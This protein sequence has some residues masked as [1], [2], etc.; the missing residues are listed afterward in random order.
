MRKPDLPTF[1]IEQPLLEALTMHKRLVLT[2]P[3]GS[4]KST[5]VPQ[6]L[7]DGGLLR[8]GQ[9]TVLQPRRL[10]TR[11]LAAWVAQARDVRLG[12]EVGYQIRLDNVTSPATRICYVTEG[13]LLRRML[14]DPGL[15][16]VSAIVFDEFHER[17]LYGDITLARA[18][19]IQESTRPDLIIIVMS[20]TL[21][22]AA[23]QKYLHPC[24][25]LSSQGRTYPVAIEYL[26]QPAGEAP[27][28][29]LAVREL[30][31]LVRRHSQGDA[32]IF[33]PGAYEIT[34]TVQAA[35][36][37][38]GRQ[39]VVFPLHGELPP[40]DQ[41]AAVA[42]YDRRKIVVA[43]N[44][45]ETSLT[46]DGVRLVI[47][48]GLARIPRYDPYRGINTLLVEKISRAAAD[49]RAGRAGRTAPGH[50]LRLWTAHD[51]AARAAQELSEVKRLDLSEVIL[52]LKASGVKDVR[53]F[54][55]LEP[56]DTRA[57][58]R[59][60]KLLTD[61][62]AIDDT[63]GAITALGR[64]M[65]AFPAH[66]R[67]ARMFLA[68]QDYGC[69][70]PVALIAALTQGRDLLVRR[71]GK[72][73]EDAR[74]DLFDE[75]TESDF[76]VLMRAWRYAERNGYHS[77]RCRRLGVHAQA[78]RQV[79]PL[80]E[81]F[82]RIA[83]AEGLDISEKSFAP[84]AVQR[85]VLVGFSDHL[86]RRLD[87]GSLR[88]ELAH[89][90]RGVLARESVVQKAPLFVV[91]EVREV[92]SRSGRDRSLNVVL[93]LATAIKEEWLRE[94]FPEDFTE[95]RAVVYDPTLKRVV[96]RDETRFR[97]LVLKEKLSDNPPVEEAAAILAREVAAGRCALENWNES[98]ERWILRVNRLREWMPELAL[99]VIGE[100]DRNAMLEL[101]CH[102]A[103]SQ[104]EIKDR[105]VWPVVKSWLSRRQQAS[106][107]EYAPERIGLPNGHTVK[108]VY[109]VDG[110]PTIAARIQD[111]YGIKEA[112]WIAN[113][114]VAVRIQVLAP[115]NRP[116]QITEN[117][118]LFWRETYPKLKQQL[119]SKY[120][121]HDWR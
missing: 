109:S 70:W 79:G 96:V 104:K 90:R 35:R 91:S 47:D 20:A 11:M 65:L 111:L 89:G 116:V 67:Y 58:E 4:G 22:V 81:Q 93:N 80:F 97:D 84:A 99:P 53:A 26:S 16:G 17:H 108:V 41:D 5:Q 33:M 32:L 92:Q 27:V 115:S 114:R 19:Q 83:A 100:E 69:V 30:Q 105:P 52:T 88:C 101:I 94:L 64:R 37:T 46:I 13:V 10:P 119:Q 43:T 55:W 34:R 31:R 42:R 40:V 103:F 117:L 12:G 56:P 18:L 98:V 54:R 68:A 76:F 38:L 25:L 49:Q 24:A 23:V 51:Q 74:D 50:C 61:L 28:W 110:P 15:K 21:D 36:D 7:L 39:F 112:L 121:K 60:E 62:G 86:A 9:V 72:Q 66:P 3:T 77:D 45:A 120:P 82:L 118:A 75:E 14:A 102:G 29:E 71:Q 59:A 78:A 73:V 48:S 107:E 1:E 44:V 95:V 85:C 87:A 6:M 106:I 57:L 8:D 2:A 113:R 63:T